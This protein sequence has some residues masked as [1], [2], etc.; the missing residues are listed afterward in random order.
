MGYGD[1]PMLPT[2]SADMKDPNEEYD[3]KDYRRNFGEPVRIF[4]FFTFFINDF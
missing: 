1:Y 3:F 4:F 2:I